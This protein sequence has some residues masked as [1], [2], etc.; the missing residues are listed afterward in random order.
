MTKAAYI[1]PAEQSMRGHIRER[2][3]GW[4]VAAK[5]LQRTFTG[6]P[7][8]TP[9][10]SRRYVT[11]EEACADLGLEPEHRKAAEKAM[12]SLV[13]EQASGFSVSKTLLG[14]GLR[15]PI[16]KELLT[17]GIR[18]VAEARATRSVAEMYVRKAGPPPGAG[19]TS[20]P[21]GKKGGFRRPKSG[22]GYE[23]AYP[24]SDG[25]YT[26]HD[27]PAAD[28]GVHVHEEHENGTPE[29]KVR[30]RMEAL[31][32]KAKAAGLDFNSA[33]TS[34]TTMKHL[35][36]LEKQL[37][38]AI[39]TKQKREKEEA[40]GTTPPKKPLGDDDVH[41]T[42]A[43]GKP[44]KKAPPAA[45]GDNAPGGASDGEP[46]TVRPAGPPEPGYRIPPRPA[47]GEESPT[48]DKPADKPVGPG[49]KAPETPPSS[50][51]GDNAE[52]AAKETPRSAASA[53][54]TELGAKKGVDPEQI[55]K[56][57]ADPDFQTEEGQKALTEHLEGLPDLPP[58]EKLP[59]EVPADDGERKKLEAHAKHLEETISRMERALS[60]ER[61]HHAKEMAALRA[62]VRKLAERAT[63]RQAATATHQVWA[64]ALITFG[65]AA[66]FVFAGPMGALLGGSMANQYLKTGIAKSER[67]RPRLA[68]GLYLVDGHL[69]LK[70][71]G[72]D[73]H[74]RTVREND[75]TRIVASR[76]A[77]LKELE[78]APAGMVPD[79]R[80]VLQT[81]D[82]HSPTWARIAEYLSPDN[83]RKLLS[84]ATAVL[85]AREPS[86]ATP[87]PAEPLAKALPAPPPLPAAAPPAPRIRGRHGENQHGHRDDLMPGQRLT[88]RKGAPGPTTVEVLDGGNFRWGDTVYPNGRQLLKALTSS[89]NPT[90]TIRRYFGL[91]ADDA[92]LAKAMC[93]AL[94]A[95]HPALLVS[96]YQGRVRV[97]GPL[98]RF[99]LPVDNPLDTTALFDVSVVQTFLSES[100]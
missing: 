54:I 87:G 10:P 63:P 76:R 2:Q 9:E 18:M 31:Q 66:G 64:F 49:D 59:D 7:P 70:S 32:T 71:D 99:G 14:Q 20:I 22:G 65:F 5:E 97:E 73:A 91:G 88:V 27:T 6:S 55:K 45:E 51:K 29:G 92:R 79:A 41:A 33:A 95:K 90:A 68:P 74:A 69:I 3:Q 58:P 78:A 80:A 84:A 48:G 30:A 21:K 28:E 42:P 38:R 16:V 61:D 46:V 15:Q 67:T 44:G 85:Q 24:D 93:D 77:M 50:P 8:A 36:E 47:D 83:R 25:G 86:E 94:R 72:D 13:A 11:A 34:R 60:V 19:W 89:D 26:S 17:R 56:L 57:L 62:E 43:G 81:L 75:P 40:A 1:K 39:A 23:Y 96:P 82:E 53:R 4:A 52:P 12:R 98:A 35:N 37:D 100:A